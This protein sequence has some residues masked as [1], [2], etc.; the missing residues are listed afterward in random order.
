MDPK[1]GCTRM[2]AHTAGSGM[3]GTNPNQW[4]SDGKKE[5]ES[6][7]AQITESVDSGGGK[8]SDNDW[9][10]FVLFL[11]VRG[12][13]DHRFQLVVLSCER[14]RAGRRRTILLPTG[15]RSKIAQNRLC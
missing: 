13:H 14:N 4:S 7:G 12:N 1:A 2:N 10:L 15:L 5:I 6:I 9:M 3:W 8:F 11:G